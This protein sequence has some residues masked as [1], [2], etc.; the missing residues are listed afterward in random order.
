[1]N[2]FFQYELGRKS[3]DAL[4]N[5][6]H[7]PRPLSGLRVSIRCGGLETKSGAEGDFTS[8]TQLFEV[9]LGC[10]I[11]PSGKLWVLPP[12]K[13]FLLRIHSKGAHVSTDPPLL[14]SKATQHSGELSRLPFGPISL[15]FNQ[16]ATD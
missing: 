9:L 3:R 1:M 6:P 2:T 4:R 16:S 8:P 12:G 13:Y 7:P 11:P 10:K 14:L 15:L 5:A